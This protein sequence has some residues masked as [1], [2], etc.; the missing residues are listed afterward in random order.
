MGSSDEGIQASS[1]TVRWTA[2]ADDGGSPITGYRVVIL[3]GDTE[4]NNL[5]I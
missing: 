1:L 3:K 5:L 2:P 4:I